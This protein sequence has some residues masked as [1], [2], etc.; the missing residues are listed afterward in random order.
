[1]A[2]MRMLV[3]ALSH[4]LQLQGKVWPNL[5]ECWIV[6]HDFAMFHQLVGLL[7]RFAMPGFLEY[8]HNGI[9]TL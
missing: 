7:Y 8:L 3:L 6:E 5:V 2:T 9:Y 4:S 1:M